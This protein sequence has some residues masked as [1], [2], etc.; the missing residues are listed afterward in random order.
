MVLIYRISDKKIAE[1]IPEVSEEPE[2]SESDYEDDNDIVD[3]AEATG[4]FTKK[5][6]A[7]RTHAIG[8]NA[9]RNRLTGKFY[10]ISAG[11]RIQNM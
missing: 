1:K 7:A 5:L 9:A 6:N 8:P 2:Y 3:F 10:A 11:F 4:D